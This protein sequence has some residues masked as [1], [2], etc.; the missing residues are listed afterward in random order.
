MSERSGLI[1]GGELR[2]I[3]LDLVTPFRTSFGEETARDVLLVAVDMEYGDATVRGWG[4]CVAMTAPLYSPEFVDAAAL[5]IEE[6]LLGRL[7]G[8]G[9]CADDV[10][11]HL[12][13]VKGHAMAK[14]AVEMAILDAELRHD[15]T[16]FASRIG[17]TR[18]RVPSGVSVGIFDDVDTLAAQVDAYMTDGYARIKLKI[19]PGWDL[20][21]VGMIRRLIGDDVPLQV[22][23]NT[24]YRREDIEHL[25][26]LDEFGLLLIE[27]PLPEED[28]LG[29][30]RLAE[31]STT[32]VCL[33]ESIHSAAGAVDAIELGAC[34]VVNIK[35]GRVGGYLEARRVHDACRQRGV[36]VWCGGMLETGIGRAPNVALAAL[37]GFTLPGDVSG[38]D[39]FWRRDIVTDPV[40]MTDGTVPVPTTPGLGFDLDIEFLD[41]VTTARRTL[42]GPL[43]ARRADG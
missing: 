29:H 7:A 36:A 3:A 15:G 26:R 42:S 21:P 28:L 43:P 30:V 41:Q 34:S 2:R 12:A 8:Q 37:D 25:C 40:R 22:D 35:P 24:A 13:P 11:G 1:A 20:E 17:A 6:H 4:E 10:A 18:T 39:R 9:L 38:A 19:E 16:P 33:D 31:R 32:P 5:V 27:Q 23:A 14:A